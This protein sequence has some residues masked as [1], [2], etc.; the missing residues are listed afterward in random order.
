MTAYESVFDFF[1]N[2]NQKKLKIDEEVFRASIKLN[3]EKY[4]GAIN[5]EALREKLK[6]DLIASC[7]DLLFDS[8]ETKLKFQNR[9]YDSLLLHEMKD[10]HQEYQLLLFKF[11][12]LSSMV[13]KQCDESQ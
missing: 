9:R 13:K 12:E 4:F 1:S 7:K 11:Q 10:F 6:T 2:L 5:E 3:R 8:N